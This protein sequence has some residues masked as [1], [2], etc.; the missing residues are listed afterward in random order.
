M[1]HLDESLS[2]SIL[3]E[4]F[5]NATGDTV[6][7]PAKTSTNKG[8]GIDYNALIAGGLGLATVLATS[9][10]QPRGEEEISCGRP[11][12][13]WNAARLDAHNKCVENLRSSN[14]GSYSNQNYGNGDNGSSQD[15]SGTYWLLIGGITLAAI[16]LGIGAYFMFR[17][18]AAAIPAT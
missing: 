16:G 2:T 17:K 15:S 10:T 8:S 18:K 13:T 7:T 9:A 4:S 12:P 11:Q 3:D 6:A 14:Q 1:K 5:N